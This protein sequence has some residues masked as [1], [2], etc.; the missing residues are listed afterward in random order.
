MV[1][2]LDTVFS[3]FIR[4][5]DDLCKCYTCGKQK[6]P[7]EMDAGHYIKRSCMRTRWDERNVKPQCTSCNRFRGGNMDEYALHLVREYGEGIIEKLMELK[8][9]PVKKYTIQELE[10]LVETYKNKLKSIEYK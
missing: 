10:N 2:K 5:T 8:H 1:D 6:D 9:E 4:K 3:K 7:K